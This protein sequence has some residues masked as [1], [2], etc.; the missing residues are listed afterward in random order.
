[1][2]TL[3]QNSVNAT[4]SIVCSQATVNV[5]AVNTANRQKR[6]KLLEKAQGVGKGV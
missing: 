5:T 2:K 1:M 3:H 4:N 6:L